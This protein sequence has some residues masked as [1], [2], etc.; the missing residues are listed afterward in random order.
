MMKP[1][2]NSTVAPRPANYTIPKGT[3]LDILLTAIKTE[4][5]GKKVMIWQA[6]CSY[7][8]KTQP[9]FANRNM[10]SEVYVKECFKKRLMPMIR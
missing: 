5:F 2:A 9:F 10:N 1:T 7:G 8:F 6:I 3:K 4:K